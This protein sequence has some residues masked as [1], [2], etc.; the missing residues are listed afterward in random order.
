MAS[1]PLSKF[2]RFDL[3]IAANTISKE[4]LDDPNQPAEGLQ[5]LL[6]SV[7]YVH[8]N[9][10]FGST[11]PIRGTR[12]NL[13]I[14]GSPKI[15]ADGISFF[16]AMGDYRT[17]FRFF[18]DYNFVWRLNGGASM[19][20][21]PQRFYIGGTPNWI[22]YTVQNDILPIEDIKDYAFATPVMPMRGFDY[23]YRSGSKFLLMNN[24]FR[25]PLFRYLIFGPLPLAFQNIQGVL[26][27]DLGSVW[28][29]T[30]KLQLISSE[31]GK[32]IT[33]D[34]LAGMGFGVRIFLLYFPLKFDVAWSYNLQKF[35]M[36]IFYIS[37]GSDF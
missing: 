37:L 22:N 36:P 34:L 16:S 28:S 3:G 4:N 13:T 6:P 2:D 29:N 17:Y 10:L 33:K 5:F 19:G 1:Y 26:F 25:F 9:T 23:N 31:N 32:P 8:D 18:N 11:A 30:K 20:P 24:E 21:N 27:T 15:G 7:G 35:S 12:Y 14:M